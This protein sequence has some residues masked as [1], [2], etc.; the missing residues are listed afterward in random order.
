MTTAQ[1][2]LTA[3]PTPYAGVRF[4]SRLEARVAA[5]L[6]RIGARWQ[7]E[8]EGFAI[9]PGVGYLPDFYLPEADTWLEVKPTWRHDP[10]AGLF[11]SFD[12]APAIYL[13]APLDRAREAYGHDA[14]TVTAILGIGSM[15]S[16]VWIKCPACDVVQPAIIGSEQLRCCGYGD[17]ETV[18]GDWFWRAHYDGTFQQGPDAYKSILVVPELP[19]YQDGHMRWSS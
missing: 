11:A 4:R 13:I 17:D 2:A 9:G 15:A 12:P 7:Y 5:G 3:L 10:K 8:P 19:Q 6:D 14:F 16:A 18:G 1:T